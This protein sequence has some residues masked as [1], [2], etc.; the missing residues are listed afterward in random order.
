MLTNKEELKK[1]RQRKYLAKDFDGF[2]S[3]ILEYVR[4]YY[5]DRLKDFSESSLGGLFLDMASYVGDNMSYYLDH[6]Y[7]ELN[8]SSAVETKNVEKHLRSLGV[9]ISGAAPAVVPVDIYVQ[10]PSEQVSGAYVPSYSALPVVQT[11]SVFR[12]DSGVYFTLIED[13]DFRKK[14]TDNTYFATVK[15][16]T[17]Y[18]DGSPKSFIMVLSGLCVS[19]TETTDTFEIGSEF[20]KFREL[21]LT[22]ANVSDIVSVSDS[23]GNKYYNVSSL[24]HDVVYTNVLNTTSDSDLVK[25]SIK[26]VPAPYRYTTKVDL[27]T[28]KTALVF[29]GGSADT[30]E[31]DI[32]PDPTDFA[33]SFPY[34]RTFSRISVNPQTLLQTKTL[35][36]A[37]TDTTVS[38][39]YR[40]GGGLNHNVKANS[41][42]NVVSVGVF[43]PSNPTPSVAASVRTSLEVSNPV[44][45]V[46]GE[47]ALSVSDYKDIAPSIKNSQERIVS[48]EDLIARIYSMPSNFGRVFR[49]SVRPNP[50]NLLATQL[51]IISRDNEK[52]LIVSPDTLK[53]NL[54]KY[55]NPYRLVSDAIDVL[56]ARVINLS[57]SY[58]IMIDPM[59]NKSVVLQLVN[60]KLQDA[61]DIK[62]FHIDQPISVADVTNVIIT[63]NGVLS[64]GGIQFTNVSSTRGNRKYSDV[65]FDVASNTKKGFVI[66]PAGGIFE[67]RYPEYDIIGRAV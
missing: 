27:S 44:S 54:K 64:I 59:L 65:T 26:V 2:R 42:R 60:K 67:I 38:V 32:I 56:D 62:N 16:G 13:V 30:L 45:A 36:V 8:I 6:Q 40:Y 10:V 12:S 18:Q 29:G 53:N 35:G 17:R 15:I 33:I 43:F 11:N 48:K 66:P 5:P 1:V 34:K 55:L 3:Q 46:G 37:T 50:G 28:R 57:L 52:K 39:R 22:Y 21:T 63:T 20:V 23:Y 31:D 41:I 58:E 61:F 14:R 25:D 47:D 9:Q 49:A 51:Y 7:G 19:G 24:T 4:L